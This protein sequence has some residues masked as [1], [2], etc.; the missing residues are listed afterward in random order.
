MFKDQVEIMA[1]PS[2][3]NLKLGNIQYYMQKNHDKRCK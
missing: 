2:H 1:K 3:F